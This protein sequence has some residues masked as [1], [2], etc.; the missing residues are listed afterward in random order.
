MEKR[1]DEARRKMGIGLATQLAR[2]SKTQQQMKAGMEAFLGLGKGSDSGRG[3]DIGTVQNSGTKLEEFECVDECLQELWDDDATWD[4]ADPVIAKEHLG[5]I[6][7]TTPKRDN[8]SCEEYAIGVLSAT[9]LSYLS[10]PKMAIPPPAVA[11]QNKSPTKI[12][13]IKLWEDMLASSSQIAREISTSETPSKPSS[14]APIGS[15]FDLGLSTQEIQDVFEEDESDD[16]LLKERENEIVNLQELPPRSLSRSSPQVF[17]PPSIPASGTARPRG[18]GASTQVLDEAPHD[19]VGHALLE[20]KSSS[21]YGMDDVEDS[22]WEAAA[23]KLL[24]EAEA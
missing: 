21:S 2:Y 8:S 1:E 15:L 5:T 22:S 6:A 24:M 17:K 20:R 12:S 23:L 18:F 10:S 14:K 7:N 19:E 13:P 4:I 11:H 3:S 16:E 9:K